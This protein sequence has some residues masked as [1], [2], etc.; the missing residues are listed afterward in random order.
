MAKR[1]DECAFL[2]LARDKFGS[3]YEYDLSTYTSLRRCKIKIRCLELDH[4]GEE[5]GWFEISPD[6]HL[7]GAGGCRYCMYSSG[8]YLCRNK[9]DFLYWASQFHSGCY[10]YSEF[11]Y[12]DGKTKGRIFC[13]V[14][15][16]GSFLVSPN[17]HLTSRSGCPKCGR[18]SA[19]SS[20]SITKGGGI[21]LLDRLLRDGPQIHA[22]KYDYSL[23]DV[24]R[25]L[26]GKDHVDLVCPRHGVFRSQ[27]TVHLAGHGCRKC[28]DEDAGAR[29]QRDQDAYIKECQEKWGH[30]D[31]YYSLVEHKGNAY[32]IILKCKW[33]GPFNCSSA[34]GHRRSGYGCPI[35][36]G[37]LK[38]TREEII[39]ACIAK[40]G[41][42]YD[43]SNVENDIKNVREKITIICRTHGEFRQKAVAHYS[44][45][46][47]CP[48]CGLT[49]SGL[50]NI[51]SFLRDE[52]RA[53][54]YCELYL[55][56]VG[57]YFKIGIA[58]DT[59]E[60][61]KRFYE[62]YI[63]VLPSKR[64]V[65]WVAEQHLLRQTA[66]MEPSSL[67]KKYANWPG[68][69]EL[70]SREL[71]VNELIDYM[72]DTLAEAEDLGWLGFARKHDLPDHGYGWDPESGL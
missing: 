57:E 20:Q 54:S 58:E 62:D 26:R 59:Y 69:S 45:G 33:H 36:S 39:Q 19:G 70:R 12:V 43:Y 50:D 64:A 4:F 38:K 40:H 44:S 9:R 2:K 1:I 28:A 53:Q 32:P 7:R 25:E 24:G 5:H 65:C 11:E 18:I 23:I 68:R 60:R 51:K 34:K 61:D 6:L 27:V 14:P 42:L 37:N 55:V 16:H 15:G 29:K 31:D 66:W 41:S 22:N 30:S 52:Q 46:Y 56:M 8:D 67:P 10:D 71:E 63:L 49:K 13:K 17:N 48:D 47:G 35:C 72:E 3:K 21:S